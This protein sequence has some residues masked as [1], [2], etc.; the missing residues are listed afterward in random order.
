MPPRTTKS[1]GVNIEARE[2]FILLES[3]SLA[4]DV[5]KKDRDYRDMPREDYVE[6][7]EAHDLWLKLE[8]TWDRLSPR[9][10][11]FAAAAAFD[12]RN[13]R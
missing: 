5:L 8:E 12:V 6:L 3:L 1:D 7:S 9:E 10:R 4:M 13:K 11:K 2:L